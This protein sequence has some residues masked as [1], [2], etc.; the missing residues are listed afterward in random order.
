MNRIVEVLG[1]PPAPM[2][3][4]APKAR[5]YFERLPGG[6]WTLRRT[7]ELRKVRP[8]PHAAPPTLVAPHSLTLGASFFPASSPLCLSLPSSPPCLSFP[9]SQPN[10]CLLP[11]LQLFL[12]SF[13]PLSLLCLCFPVCVSLP[14]LPTDG[15]SLAPP[16]TPSLP[17][18]PGPRDTAAAGGAGRADGRARGPAGGGAGPQPR[19]LPPL[20]G[21]GA[22]HVGV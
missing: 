6:G 19:R 11:T 9:S 1:I 14:L 18:L 8:L 12:A 16:P 5:K 17:G 20:P 10:P 15:H 22:A 4:Q 2:L 3:D 7:K 13:L 21:P